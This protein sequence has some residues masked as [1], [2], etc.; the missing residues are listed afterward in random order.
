MKNWSTS[1]LI[2]LGLVGMVS[3]QQEKREFIEQDKIIIPI[4]ESVWQE[5]LDAMTN[6][7]FKDLPETGIEVLQ[8]ELATTPIVGSFTNENGGTIIS[9]DRLFTISFPANACVLSTNPNTAITGK[10]DVE[11]KLLRKNGEI[12]MYNLPSVATN[13]LMTSGGIIWIKANKDGQEL[14]LRKN[15]L[16]K[17]R[18]IS[19]DAPDNTM[20]MMDGNFNGRFKFD[21]GKISG[22]LG[23]TI[24]PLLATWRDSLRADSIRGYDLT[25]DRFGAISCMRAYSSTAALTNTF[26]VRVGVTTDT[27]SNINTRVFLLFRELNMVVPLVGNS[28][29]KVFELPKNLQNIPTN[30]QIIVLTLTYFKGQYFMGTQATTTVANQ[31]NPISI[32]PSRVISKEELRTRVG[33]L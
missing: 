15:L 9:S 27:F 28:A 33:L 7:S 30:Q 25:L 13:R 4:G 23:S 31:I 26:R 12:A 17:V 5:N 10:I 3:C 19:K 24:Q 32:F 29:S 11:V 20:T 8:K 21:W 1:I 22:S 6:T 2:I 18:F 14:Q 16:Y